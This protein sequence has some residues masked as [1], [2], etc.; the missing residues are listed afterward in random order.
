MKGQEVELRT[1]AQNLS[2]IEEQEI[3]LQLWVEHEDGTRAVTENGEEILKEQ[4]F[5]VPV[6]DEKENFY[7][8]GMRNYSGTEFDSG[9][10]NCSLIYK[11]P[12]MQT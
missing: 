3:T 6:W 1:I 10:M 7:I 2:G 8:K 4:T 12:E 5:T 9:L 11:I